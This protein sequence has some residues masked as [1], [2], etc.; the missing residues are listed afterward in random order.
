M[1][2]AMPI[3]TAMERV[4]ALRLQASAEPRLA[5]AL[6]QIKQFQALRFSATYQDLLDSE[7]YAPCANFFLDELYSERDF[8]SRD[9]QFAKVADAIG[10][11]FPQR[12]TTLTSEL[13]RLHHLTEMLDFRMAKVWAGNSNHSPAKR[14]ALAWRQ[15]DCAADRQWQ[16]TT[17]LNIG[18]ELG[19]LTQKRGL[20]LLLKMMRGPALASGLGELQAFLEKGFA[21]FGALSR[22]KGALHHFLESIRTNEEQWIHEMDTLTPIDCE[23]FIQQR[24]SAFNSEMSWKN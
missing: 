23:H 19:V 11:T 4:Q 15:L 8:Q 13:A 18:E 12:V 17:V 16:L 3:R 1:S 24:M 10:R 9:A 2:S 21:T 5:L 20:L 14:Y 6:Q 7:L 22:S